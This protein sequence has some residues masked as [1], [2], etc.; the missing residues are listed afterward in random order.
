MDHRRC[1]ERLA[2]DERH[3]TD[4]RFDATGE[5]HGAQKLLQGL[6]AALQEGVGCFDLL[7]VQMGR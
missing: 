6:C 7:P 2:G 4:F 5:F 3:L 1:F